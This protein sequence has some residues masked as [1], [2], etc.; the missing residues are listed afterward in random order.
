MPMIQKIVTGKKRYLPLLLMADPSEK[1]I[2][3][4]LDKGALYIMKESQRTIA[5]AVMF[6][7]GENRYELKNIAVLPE[8][9][10]KGY[11]TRFL[12]QLLDEYEKATDIFVGTGSTGNPDNEF[13]QIGFYR[14]CGFVYSHT[15]KNFFIDNYPQPIIE[16]NGMQCIDMIFLVR[17]RRVLLCNETHDRKEEKLSAD[18]SRNSSKKAGQ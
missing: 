15:V 12:L 6:P 14:K 2:A 5:A 8:Y 4:Y 7:L 9:R 18:E 11:G 1:M 16:E 13:Y 17:K 10:K 3:G